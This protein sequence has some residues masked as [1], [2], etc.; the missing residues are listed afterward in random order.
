[1]LLDSF[2]SAKTIFP[3][4]QSRWIIGT[5]SS[6]DIVVCSSSVSRRHCELV[7]DGTNF[8]L[9]D[10]GSTNGTFVNGS[11]IAGTTRVQRADVITMGPSCPLPWPEEETASCGDV[12]VTQEV[13]RDNRPLVVTVGRS[14]ENTVVLEEPNVSGVHARI[15]VTPDEIIVEDLGS[16]NGTAVGTVSNK[17]H[18]ASV[19]LD[20]TLFLGSTPFGVSDLLQ[21][22]AAGDTPS[23][24]SAAPSSTDAK[25]DCRQRV[26][27][28][29]AFF[30]IPAILAIGIFLALSHYGQD[31]ASSTVPRRLSEASDRSQTETQ[32]GSDQQGSAP[33][34]VADRAAATPS[35]EDADTAVTLEHRLAQSL[36]VVACKRAD[37]EEAYR[38]G[39]AFASDAH[40]LV[41]S[42]TVLELLDEY[43]QAD[44]PVV[45]VYNPTLKRTFHPKTWHIHPDFA[46][47][48]REAEAARKAHDATRKRFAAAPNAD[49]FEEIKRQLVAERM[50]GISAT[51]AKTSLDV[52]I[53]E[54]EEPLSIWLPLAP[55]PIR[56]RPRQKLSIAGLAIDREDMFFDP[57]FPIDLH[58]M[59]CRVKELT[60]KTQR[61]RPRLIAFCPPHQ[62]GYNYLGSPVLNARDEVVAVYSRPTPPSYRS[63]DKDAV[64]SA[65]DAALVDLID[66]IPRSAR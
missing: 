49:D 59:T 32:S 22:A 53:I 63:E 43:R 29:A 31:H 66:D 56:L 48:A 61:A 60:G 33:R 30:G 34:E 64:P 44:Y 18:R 35:R 17:I 4:A 54:L 45:I 20:A 25:P 6:C 62:L 1:M 21:R 36:F 11:R 19:T 9:R 12:G 41:T 14:P 51:D 42:A 5:D 47:V 16:T 15:T 7:K 8:C 46:S 28:A 55:R 2:H 23:R 37:G 58:V 26:V 13:S 40:S 3:M 57:D 52:G 38:L 10:L 24:T 27:Q 65:C 50:K 39:T